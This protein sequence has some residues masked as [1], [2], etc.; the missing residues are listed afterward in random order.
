MMSLWV[1]PRKTLRSGSLPRAS[2]TSDQVRQR[3]RGI[4]RHGTAFRWREQLEFAMAML[5]IQTWICFAT[6]LLACSSF[7]TLTVGWLRYM[8]EN[9]FV[10]CEE[11]HP[12]AL[13]RSV[14]LSHASCV[15]EALDF[16][17]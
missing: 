16:H 13:C 10:A 4:L 9:G 2:Q 11:C 6:E 1:Q 17:Q 8:Y 7:L 5:P 12:P 3:A 15:T 14:D